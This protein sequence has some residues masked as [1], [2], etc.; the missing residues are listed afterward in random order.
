M[1]NLGFD[2]AQAAYEHA[3]PPA[4][5]CPVCE[6][7]RQV[8]IEWSGDYLREDNGRIQAMPVPRGTR[9]DIFIP[10]PECQGMKDTYICK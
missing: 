7:T 2:R 10:C 1:V 4:G 6:D 3:E 9:P 8:A 5:H